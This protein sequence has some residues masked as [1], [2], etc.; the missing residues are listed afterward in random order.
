M[1]K[2]N[3]Q[4][5]SMDANNAYA[6][7]QLGGCYAT[8]EMGMP[9]DITK[10][11]ELWHRAGEIGCSYAYYNLGISYENGDGVEMDKKKAKHYYE[12]A[13]M[14]GSLD[15][16]YNLGCMEVY[17]GNPDRA[18]KHFILAA[19]AGENKSLDWVRES[20]MRG[21][22]TKDEYANSLRAFQRAHDETKSDQR[23]KARAHKNGGVLR[24]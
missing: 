2:F 17:A 5:N 16:R 20:L 7:H 12:L 15:A 3:E 22:V 21:V 23:D 18:K 24:L 11:N 8:G 6:F 13:A 4:K 1:R 19:R 10:A 14:N 9:R